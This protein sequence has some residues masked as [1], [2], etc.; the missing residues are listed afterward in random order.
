M[1]VWWRFVVLQLPS[2]SP[3]TLECS[4]SFLGILSPGG[5]SL[6]NC[7]ISILLSTKSWAHEQSQINW[8]LDSLLDCCI[9]IRAT[10]GNKCL[11][12]PFQGNLS[13]FFVKSIQSSWLSP[14]LQFCET[15]YIPLVN[16]F[17]LILEAVL[18]LTPRNIWL[19]RVCSL[20]DV[21]ASTSM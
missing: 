4:I 14:S 21:Y 15:P 7:K 1:C 18:L 16:A 17:L 10:R 8:T 13:G 5:Y 9:L 11:L 20:T 12:F 2:R 3:P 6:G 19:I